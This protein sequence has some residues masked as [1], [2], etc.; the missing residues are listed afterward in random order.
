MTGDD[1]VL[2]DYEKVLVQAMVPNWVRKGLKREAAQ[3]RRSVANLLALWL[4]DS[5]AHYPENPINRP[6]E[7]YAAVT[8]RPLE[9]GPATG[10]PR[11]LRH[12]ERTLD[13][14]PGDE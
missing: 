7:P 3:E 2:G 1:K 14:M 12:Q 10:A 9:A 11:R 8:E 4:E 13:E 5:R 6:Q